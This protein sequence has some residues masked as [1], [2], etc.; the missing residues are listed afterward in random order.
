MTDEAGPPFEYGSLE[1]AVEDQ[2]AIEKAS[3]R[4]KKAN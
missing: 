4:I 3:E 1:R 2:T